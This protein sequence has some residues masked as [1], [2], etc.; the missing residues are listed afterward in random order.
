MTRISARGSP[1]PAGQV[2]YETEVAGGGIATVWLPTGSLGVG[3]HSALVL[4]ESKLG[5]DGQRS[6]ACASSRRRPAVGRPRTAPLRRRIRAGWHGEV[7]HVSPPRL[8]LD[9]RVTDVWH[10]ALI[11]AEEPGAPLLWSPTRGKSEA[12]WLPLSTSSILS[13]LCFGVA[14]APYSKAAA[15]RNRCGPQAGPAWQPSGRR[16]HDDNRHVAVLSRQRSARR[17][18]FPGL[19]LQ[20]IRIRWR[21]FR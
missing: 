3:P 10:T 14:A 17:R 15:R 13:P 11:F 18:L 7:R 2:N 4:R 1:A 16:F 5:P 21:R 19:F 9:A 8:E 12:N 20:W 6:A